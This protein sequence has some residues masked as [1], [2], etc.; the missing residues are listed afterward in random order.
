MLIICRQSKYNE[1]SQDLQHQLVRI[2][3]LQSEYNA[4]VS[5]LKKEKEGNKKGDSDSVHHAL[6]QKCVELENILKTKDEESKALQKELEVL[7]QENSKIQLSHEQDFV[8]LQEKLDK[9]QQVVQEVSNK[10]AAL[11]SEQEETEHLL[12]EL[13]KEKE[14]LRSETELW[15]QKYEGLRS[16]EQFDDVS[17]MHKKEVH[18]QLQRV[19]KRV[20]ASPSGDADK[21]PVDSST[22][23]LNSSISNNSLL[24]DLEWEELQKDTEQLKQLQ[25]IH[26][27]MDLE[28]ELN[29][30]R[31]ERN[32]LELEL[33]KIRSVLSVTSTPS[34][35]VQQSIDNSA[36]S[37]YLQANGSPYKLTSEVNDSI[38]LQAKL[39]QLE[40][41]DAVNTSHDEELSTT[42]ISNLLTT[43]QQMATQ[44]TLECEQLRD[45]LQQVSAERD[46]LQQKCNDVE[47]TNELEKQKAAQENELLKEQLKSLHELKVWS[48]R[49][50]E[51][52]EKQREE[53]VILVATINRLKEQNEKLKHNGRVNHPAHNQTRHH[54]DSVLPP[55]L[56]GDLQTSRSSFLNLEE[57]MRS[58]DAT[59]SESVIFEDQQ[60]AHEHSTNIMLSQMHSLLEHIRAL[61]SKERSAYKA[62]IV[63]LRHQLAAERDVTE[64]MR[65]KY[66]EEH[67]KVQRDTLDALRE[68]IQSMKSV[69]SEP[70][71]SEGRAVQ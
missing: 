69:Y 56:H 57:S 30:S 60:A 63:R 34:L 53:N 64:A 61:R 41:L 18:K 48:D 2:T 33:E 45:E 11:A 7:T 8:V 25:W 5:E 16:R 4:L 38:E 46:R 71:V 68:H 9:A 36:P 10:Y 43:Q 50:K 58:E 44:L 29:T 28:E 42:E 26:K 13:W 19:I 32:K 59:D 1:I 15:Q 6:Q 49:L 70:I 54:S 3:D 47:Q 40:Q 51:H 67:A 20:A 14:Q 66:E 12:D 23:A 55:R 17:K 22:R 39:A 37:N 21:D 27:I 65:G 24:S 52:I 35:Q 31:S 62:Q